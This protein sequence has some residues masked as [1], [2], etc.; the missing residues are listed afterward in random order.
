MATLTEQNA[1]IAGSFYV[2]EATDFEA[3]ALWITWA[4]EG[5][6]KNPNPYYK[7]FPAVS[8]KQDNPGQL[9]TVGYLSGH[10]VCISLSWNRLDGKSVMFW[11][12]TSRVVDHGMIDAWLTKMSPAYRDG[13]RCDPM[14]FGGCLDAVRSAHG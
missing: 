6:E 13:K 9:A 14:N 10:P 11:Y 12:A 5:R 7:D 4:K 3:L 2:V 8:W 1:K